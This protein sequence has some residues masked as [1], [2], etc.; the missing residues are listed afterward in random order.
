MI[1]SEILFIALCVCLTVYACSSLWNINGRGGNGTTAGVHRPNVGA[2]WPF[3]SQQRPHFFFGM[4]L[5]CVEDGFICLSVSVCLRFFR[6]R[7]GEF[8]AKNVLIALINIPRS[9]R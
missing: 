6:K 5:G 4:D 7:R 2:G 1:S 8:P 9:S 3:T